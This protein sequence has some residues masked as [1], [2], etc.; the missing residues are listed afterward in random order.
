MPDALTIRSLT[1]E[2]L[3]LLFKWLNEG[4]LRPYY[5]KTPVSFRAV[6]QKYRPRL[7]PD[8]LVTCLIAEL[9][10][11]PFGYLQWYYNR[12][13][14]DYGIDVI[15]EPDGISLDYFIGEPDHLGKQLGSHML[16]SALARIGKN[17]AG[18]NKLCFVAHHRDNIA[19]IRCATLAGFAFRK[20]FFEDGQEHLLFVHKGTPL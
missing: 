7:T 9:N 18:T 15:A 12:D 13:F 4:H 8:H 19:A 6:R 10:G 11:R 17:L 20:N 5:R 14:P 3:P 2:D 16:N 1:E